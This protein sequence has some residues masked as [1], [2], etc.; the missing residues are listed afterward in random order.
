M[1]S[2][3]WKTFLSESVELSLMG[4]MT[5]SFISLCW[6]SAFVRVPRVGRLRWLDMF[7]LTFFS[8]PVKVIGMLLRVLGETS[9]C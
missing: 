9:T 6:Y 3:H 5:L 1:S 4:A 2:P 8:R 7:L